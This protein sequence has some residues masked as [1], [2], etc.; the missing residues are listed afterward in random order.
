M[1]QKADFIEPAIFCQELILRQVS[2]ISILI[3]VEFQVRGEKAF[4]AFYFQGPEAVHEDSKD[5]VLARLLATGP[6]NAVISAT[7]F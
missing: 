4:S 2:A 1:F 7:I 5:F 6:R 3:S